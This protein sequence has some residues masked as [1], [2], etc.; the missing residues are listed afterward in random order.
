MS[1]SHFSRILIFCAAL[2]LAR[3]ARAQAGDLDILSRTVPPI[4]MLQFDTSGSMKNIILPPKYLTDRGATYPTPEVWYN[5]A[6]DVTNYPASFIAATST[7]YCGSSSGCVANKVNTAN[8]EDYRP[9]CQMFATTSATTG[10][11][12]ICTPVATPGNTT[13][14]NGATNLPDD[15]QDDSNPQG[16]SVTM[17]CWSVPNGCLNVPAGIS[18][19]T[20]ARNRKKTSSTTVSQQYTIITWPDVSY[21]STTDYPPNYLWWMMQQIYLGQTPVTFI[22]EDRNGAGKDAITQLVNNVN[23][24]G[25]PPRVKFGLARYDGSSSYNGGYTVVVPDLNNKATLLSTLATMPAS[26]YTP[27][28]ETLVDV[29]RYL[30]GADKLGKYPAYSRNLSGGNSAPVPP[31]PVTSSCEKLFIVA[32]TDGLP[33]Q[34]NND[35]Y[36]T[37]FAQ[38]FVG[39][40]NADGSYLNDVAAKLYATDLRP[41]LSG[42]QNVITYTV[43]FTVASPILQTAAAAGHGIYFQSNN[44]DDLA[45]S[46]TTA[47]TDIIARNTTLSSAT[48]P[49]TRSAFGNG[50]YTAYFVPSGHKTV[51]PGH[52]EAYTLAADLVVLDDN[53]QPAIDPVTSLFYEPRHPHWDVS[54]TLIAGYASRKVYTTKS[55]TRVDFTAANTIDPAV[56]TATAT[57]ITT[58]MLGLTAADKNIY[59]KPATDPSIAGPPGVAGSLEPLGDSI[60]NF[61]RGVDSFD[62]NGNGSYTDVRP[63]VFGDVFHSSPVAVGPPLP[64]LRFETGYGPSTDP[65]SFMS[66]YG[67]RKRVLY[68]GA[69]DGMLHGFAAGDFVDPN[70]TGGGDEYYT[71][72]N[73]TEL[74]GYVPGILLPKVKMLPRDDI[75]AKQY[76]VDGAPSAADAWIDYNGDGVKQGSEWTTVM[77]APMR[78]GGEGI[79]ALDVT[80]PTS[81]TTSTHGPYPRL[82]WEFTNPGLGQTWSRP[83]I[84]R[85]KMRGTLGSGD[86]CGLVDPNDGDCFEKWVAIFGAGYENEANPNMGVYASDPNN[87]TL[88]KG[89]GVFIVDLK[90]GA[91][92]A[93]L[94][95]AATGEFA[96]MKYAIAAE[97]AV[98]DLDS[99]GFAD[100]VYIGDAGGQ[101]WKWDIHA[102]GSPAT[103]PIPTTVWPAGR[104]FESK[105]ATIAAG[106]LHYHSIFQ[107]AAAA[108]EKGVLTLSFA[109]G[110]RADL[111]YMGDPNTADPNNPMGLYD[112][113]NRFWV[114]QD[115]H[116]MGVGAFPS[117]LPIWETAAS[118]HDGLTD[119]TN[120][121]RDDNGADAG[122]FFKAPEGEKFITDHLIFEG[123]VVTLAYMPDL[124]G[125]GADGSCALGG[126][127][128]EFAWTLENGVGVLSAG[129][130]SS[131][132]A[133]PVRTK[134]LGNGAPTN[135]RITISKT[136]TGE[137]VVNATVQ[138]SS[139]E[140]MHPEGLPDGFDPVQQIFWRQDF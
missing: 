60:V 69:N 56:T 75:G 83:I 73:G 53:N 30:A 131:S 101:M 58:T 63:F 106:L 82:M 96:N 85:V 7:Y 100:L 107:G 89:R 5:K 39:A 12:S 11:N 115:K 124:A 57:N 117:N 91:V 99:D 77:L 137:I 9:T 65:N 36:G 55:G 71:Q 67:H 44:A 31:S 20:A 90:T 130:G 46:L 25:Q 2:A 10:S 52:L 136:D 74:F 64:F 34:D 35:H 111:G 49:S 134:S 79:L 16:G 48:V 88:S 43:G 104:L 72:G 19:T 119:I 112:D 84:T 138:T 110:E 129:G 15:D 40:S 123:V 51:W 22:A 86:H 139:G 70:G 125:S 133:P 45:D 23:I 122:Y 17:R 97:P 50:F 127:T 120:T 135:P 140:V 38:T 116:P 102:V 61:V 126:D 132:T 1:R 95:Q 3:D 62:E 41:T 76:F 87:V 37:N 94:K 26:G 27:L 105:P 14:K 32:I 114:V 93:Q 13:C 128:F 118:G 66:I 42:N 92:I 68:V 29:G 81:T 78:E 18:C 103:G 98:I 6:N 8:V 33:T 54:Q 121:E 80:D 113:N 59:P 24:D 21:T 108:L 47:I 109:S 28:S 4:V